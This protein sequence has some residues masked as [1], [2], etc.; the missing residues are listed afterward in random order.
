MSQKRK[1]EEEEG[2]G[3]A[4][5]EKRRKGKDVETYKVNVVISH[6]KIKSVGVDG[7]MLH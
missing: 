1:K 3:C 4:I 6:P 5:T 7:A 2:L